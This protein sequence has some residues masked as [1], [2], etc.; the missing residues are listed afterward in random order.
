M[1]LRISRLRRSSAAP[2]LF[3][4]L[5]AAWGGAVAAPPLPTAAELAATC[6]HLSA[7]SVAS[8]LPVANTTIASATWVAA[9]ATTPEHCQID[10]EVNR[11][12]GI[13]GKSYAIRFRM[14][15]PVHW[16]SRFFMGGG[17]GTNGNLV[18]PVARVAEGYATIGTDS[19]HDNGVHN[20]PTAGGTAAFGLDPQA[21]V[22]F[23]YNAYDRV[24][25]IGKALVQRFY[26]KAAS[27]AYFVGCSE[28]GREGLLMTQRFPQHHD[29]VVSG[30]PVLHLPLGPLS[31]VFTTQL[32]AGLATRS[33]LTLANGQPA[34]NKTYS[35]TDLLLMRSAV[36]GACDALD[37]L[38]DGIV[39][40]L[41]ACTKP[42]V[43]AQLAALTC[44]G[45]K[46][47]ACLS[48]D[49]IAT[50]RKAF[51]GTFDS[52]GTQL[53]SDWQWD[54]G[55]GGLNGNTY[56]P[57]W[58]SWWLGSFASATNNAIKLNFATAL[59]VAYTTPP[60]PV[61][62]ADSLAYSLGYDFDT[63]PIKLYVTSGALH[64]V[65]RAALLHRCGRPER[66]QRPRRQADS[67]SPGPATPRCRSMTR[68]VGLQGNEPPDGRRHAVVRPHVRGARHGALQRRACHRQLRHAAATG[69]LGREGSG[70][71]RRGGP[72]H[73]PRL[74][75]RGLAQPPAVPLPEA[76]PLQRFRAT[77]T[78][79]PTSAAA[80]R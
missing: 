10:G 54:A 29:G 43:D 36:L 51:D 8:A 56:N 31:G 55:I 74:L 23:A 46:T 59:A 28:G 13:D 9:S 77:S 49:Q 14:R 18:D 2:L 44:S 79:P 12:T 32:F 16:N 17:G 48:A 57:S 53:Y 1:K 19:G 68:C 6:P 41:P 39:D 75:R 24:T 72:G 62:T 80:N 58:R 22:D 7:A 11:R 40:N 21:R 71:R 37:G 69:R 26:T 35:D 42:L 67:V 76:V 4:A 63:E 5:G 20:V 64:A 38:A 52:R 47:E 33:G 34:I 78:T 65:G 25:R 60:R 45:A 30:D 73:E 27:H 70:A 61:A 15:M 3:C 66:L 50:M